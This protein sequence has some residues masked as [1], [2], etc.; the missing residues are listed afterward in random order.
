MDKPY[1]HLHQLVPTTI[2]VPII[3]TIGAED[4]KRL[5]VL[6]EHLPPSIIMLASKISDQYD[7]KNDP[8]SEVL[9][10]AIASL[11]L[12]EKKSLLKKVLRSPQ[13]HQALGVL[14]QAIRDGGLPSVADA[15]DVKVQN[16]GY[17]ETGRVP[18]GGGQAVEAFINGVKQTLLDKR[19]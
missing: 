10:A 19:N 4:P 11:T 3:D 14:T 18:L 9:D 5:D 16:G 13:F 2:T 12:E 1:P 6:L 8:T 7:G 15:L 17:I